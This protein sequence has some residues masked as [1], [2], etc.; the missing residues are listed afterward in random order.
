[1]DRIAGVGSS[2]D[3]SK[4]LIGI[5]CDVDAEA[6][7][8]LALDAEVSVHHAHGARAIGQREL[9]DVFDI[10]VPDCTTLEE[11]RKL[12]RISRMGGAGEHVRHAVPARP[13]IRIH[14]TVH[15]PRDHARLPD[16]VSGDYRIY[17]AEIIGDVRCIDELLDRLE[18]DREDIAV[19][20]HADS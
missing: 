16:R 10:D 8:E 14:G 17:R 1:M 12:E 11:V 3:T 15:Q 7:G 18:S 4:L 5:A 6:L 2:L 20:S 9:T 19:D 13:A